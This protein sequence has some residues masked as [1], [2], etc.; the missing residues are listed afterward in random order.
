MATPN[1]LK[2]IQNAEAL[3][4]ETV[5]KLGSQEAAAKALGISAATICVWMKRAGYE[6][7][8]VWVKPTNKRET[9]EIVIAAIFGE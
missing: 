8:S 4:P 7:R 9:S 3:I 5:N 2:H 6:R 1:K